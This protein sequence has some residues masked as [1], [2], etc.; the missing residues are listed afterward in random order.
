M[1]FSPNSL[2]TA[3]PRIVRDQRSGRRLVLAF[4]LSLASLIV[5]RG[6]WAQG[7]S[8]GPSPSP[9]LVETPAR[10]DSL[11]TTQLLWR[12]ESLSLVLQD[13]SNRLSSS[14][15]IE[16]LNAGLEAREEE[17]QAK[18]EATL[19]TLGGTPTL[20]E[21]DDAGQYW[22]ALLAGN[23]A[24]HNQLSRRAAIVNED[25][26]ALEREQQQWQGIVD[27]NQNP[28]AVDAV[29]DRVRD[30]LLQ[31]QALV[32]RASDQQRSVVL[33]QS[34]LAAEDAL[35]NDL[36]SR[37]NR[38]RQQFQRRLF[39]RDSL[40]IWK[41][42]ARRES[43]EAVDIAANGPIGTYSS[44]D[45]RSIREQSGRLTAIALVFLL[46][47]VISLSLK[48]KWM[49]RAAESTYHAQ[50]AE[51]FRHPVALSLLAALIM[52]GLVSLSVP[53]A[54][55]SLMGLAMLIPVLR[56]LP[57]VI[58]RHWRPLLYLLAVSFMPTVIRHTLVSPSPL[59][60]ELDAL[61]NLG[62]V[63]CFCIF[64]LT[65][66][67][68]EAT[69]ADFWSRA[70][71][72][73][74]RIAIFL[75]VIALVANVFGFLRLSQVLSRAT[76]YS[77]FVGVILFTT[78]RLTMITL[79]AVL[80]TD[81]ARALA[82]VRL[83]KALILQWTERVLV[84]IGVLFW[85]ITTTELFLVREPVRAAL[86]GI[87]TWR[88]TLGTLST[89]LGSVLT[90]LVVLF[91]GFGFS[92]AVR[93]VLREEVLA[94]VHLSRGLPE[95]I[96]TLLYYGLIILVVIMAFGAAGV[97][98]SR[99]T[100]LTGALGVG[101]GFGLQNIVNNFV[102]GLILQF[103]RPIHV[104]DILEVGGLSGEVTRIGVRSSTIQTAQ[105][106]EV[107]VPNAELVAGRVINWTLSSERRRVDIP[108]TVA[109]GTE[110]KRVVDL[111]I[112]V[113]LENRSVMR[114]PE[115][116]VLF[117]GMSE[118][119]LTFELRFWAPDRTAYPQLKSDVGLAVIEA[120][121]AAKIEVPT[122]QRDLY[123]RAIEETIK[124]KLGG[125]LAVGSS[126]SPQPTADGVDR[127]RIER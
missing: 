90:V 71:I 15:D 51:I 120:M 21:L 26:F 29:Y 50:V 68:R 70:T 39:D 3:R 6:A 12:V 18:S 105:G 2:I 44:V 97:E 27:Q 41:F 118:T 28:N 83:R 116:V 86:L 111:L 33:L 108:V 121:T 24:L 13:I 22:R 84:T 23:V 36:L 109:H 69:G 122:T 99:L 102:S 47:L 88:L 64:T 34:R 98:F 45:F 7:Q 59:I 96:T 126:E 100:L 74:A 72:R 75:L 127:T 43:G 48:R 35:A 56:L 117:Q 10:T 17:V 52:T 80:K 107:I 14:A 63:L 92:T 8:P 95:L 82:T 25:V 103:E 19:G 49:R 20:T 67:F 123:L 65:R 40:P 5:A 94:R 79:N 11:T 37:V 38:E 60:R 9:T 85:L 66:K 87:L 54:L 55:L 61:F 110:P 32:G 124:E 58:G 53:L 77:T 30:A 89:S 104:G 46:N 106:A 73:A 113:A 112:R 78:V 81:R 62:V 1:W 4:G 42:K 125:T 101:I 115:P 31:I 76:I 119:G 16:A 91:V 57:A 93:F 114:A